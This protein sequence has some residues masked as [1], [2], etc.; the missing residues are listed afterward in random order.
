MKLRKLKDF[1]GKYNIKLYDSQ[2]RILA[3]LIDNKSIQLGGGNNSL[4]QILGNNTFEIEYKINYI[5][6]Y[7]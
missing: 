5:F 3:S 6:S 7:C 1:L 2:Y 4:K